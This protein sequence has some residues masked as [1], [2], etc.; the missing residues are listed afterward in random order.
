MPINMRTTTPEIRVP[1]PCATPLGLAAWDPTVCCSY[2]C[3][4]T[5][6]AVLAGVLLILVA[7]L[8]LLLALLVK[9]TSAGPAFY[10]QTRLGRQG[11]LFQLFKLRT[12]SHECEKQSG[13][14]W[15]TPGDSRITPLGRWLRRTH[16]DELPQLWNVL[17]GEMSLVGP[18]P[19][20][21]EFV[22]W[23]EQALPNYR[24]RL[25]VRP[26]ITG[27]AQVQ[28]PPDTDLADVRRKLA[29]DRYYV[30]RFT[31]WLD[32]RILATTALN[33]IGFPHCLRSRLRLVPGASVVE[34]AV[35]VPASKRVELPELQPA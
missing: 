7:P 15:C 9:L 30:Y 16:L 23:L 27:L 8:V 35:L 2:R 17:R 1:L 22:S 6:D 19:E 12:M 11:R 4:V 3:K 21:P 33:L 29:Y 31:P 13:P 18:R 5:G 34:S 32:L 28:L 20:R 10:S 24:E 14:R 25:L 26:G